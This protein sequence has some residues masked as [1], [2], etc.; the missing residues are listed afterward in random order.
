MDHLV[1]KIAGE[2]FPVREAVDRR[3][4]LQLEQGD[5]L[6]ITVIA[7]GRGLEALPLQRA[8]GFDE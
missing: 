7:F 2:D 8:E 4:L 6:V 3:Y 1:F 5:L